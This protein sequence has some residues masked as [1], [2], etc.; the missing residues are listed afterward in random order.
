MAIVHDGAPVWFVVGLIADK[1]ERILCAPLDI[2]EYWPAVGGPFGAY[3]PPK[4]SSL[5]LPDFPVKNSLC[6]LQ[7][8][9]RA[10][11]GVPEHLVFLRKD[12]VFSGPQGWAAHYPMKA[13]YANTSDVDC[14]RIAQ[15]DRELLRSDSGNP[16]GDNVGYSRRRSAKTLDVMK[17]RML[18]GEKFAAHITEQQSRSSRVCYFPFVMAPN[19]YLRKI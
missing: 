11:K 12:A 4:S 16:L 18:F 13:S 5:R 1:P 2:V 14:T 10:K 8:I 3:D 6:L 7:I 15:K 17:I 9:A 19:V